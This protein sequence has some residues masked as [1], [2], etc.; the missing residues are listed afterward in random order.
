MTVEDSNGGPDGIESR[1]IETLIDLREER[2]WS[3]SEL[4]R[5]MVEAGWPKYTQ[6]S[7][8]RTEKGE[9]PI[10]LNEAEALANVFGVEMYELWLPQKLRRYSI[11]TQD[12]V[13]R[14]EKLLKD[15]VQFLKQQRE[16]ALVADAADLADTEISYAFAVLS[17]TPEVIVRKARASE[18][19]ASPADISYSERYKPGLQQAI[20][21]EVWPR[22]KELPS[23]LEHFVAALNNGYIRSAGGEHQEEA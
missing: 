5:R 3:Q 13:Q 6:M 14:Q 11:A 22:E 4:A 9:R 18:K 16:L 19:G 10:R 1:V 21:E 8:S 20:E 12:L 2:G 23:S 7:V 17:E 15:V